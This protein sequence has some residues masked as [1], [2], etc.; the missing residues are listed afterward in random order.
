M[1]EHDTAF[2]QITR[3]QDAASLAEQ[4]EWF[5]RTY[6]PE[7]RNEAARFHADLH[8]LTRRIYADAQAPILAQWTAMMKA[9]PP[10]FPEIVTEK[11]S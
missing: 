8:M 7:D 2:E 9:L 3:W 10:L 4:I 1:A 11:K 5:F 6:A